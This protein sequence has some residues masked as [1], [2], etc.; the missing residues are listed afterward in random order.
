MDSC[1]PQPA[2]GHGALHQV[3][4]TRE[5]ESA[6]TFSP[7]PLIRT[8]AGTTVAVDFGPPVTMSAIHARGGMSKI[9]LMDTINLLYKA[10]SLPTKSPKAAIEPAITKYV[11]GFSRSSIR[12][13]RKPDQALPPVTTLTEGPVASSPRTGSSGTH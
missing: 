12:K 5:P 10:A 3:S 13:A 11:I 1:A 4:T 7:A 6:H 8:L 2:R 9:R